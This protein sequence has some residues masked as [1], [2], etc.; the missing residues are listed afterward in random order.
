MFP[1]A[2]RVLLLTIL[3]LSTASPASYGEL[4]TS[5]GTNG[6]TRIDYTELHAIAAQP[7]GKVVVAGV[8]GNNSGGIVYRRHA[9]GD[10]DLAF[11]TNGQVTFAPS[12]VAVRIQPDGKIL[13]GLR[14][15]VFTTARLNPNGSLDPTWGTGGLAQ[16]PSDG[17][18][19]LWDVALLPDGKVLAL[20]FENVEIVPGSGTTWRRIRVQRFTADGQL[21]TSFGVAGVFSYD[22]PEN[23]SDFARN[24]VLAPNGRIYTVGVG[25]VGIRILALH[26]WGALDAS[27]GSGG[28][29]D[30]P[31]GNGNARGGALTADGTGL[32]VV[33][34][35]CGTSSCA[36][37]YL[38]ANGAIDTTFGQSGR[39][40]FGI[41]PLGSMADSVYAL[42]GGRV[43]IA[44]EAF[45]YDG[46]TS[47][48][49][50]LLDSAGNQDP[51]FNGSG[52][53]V[54]SS[55]PQGVRA[56][57]LL[58]G[59]TL[60]IAG[61]KMRTGAYFL[62]ILLVRLQGDL[63]PPETSIT[64]GPPAFTNQTT[65]QIS[66]TS[67]EPG[68]TFEC[69]LDAGAFAPC[70]SP[71]PLSGLA[72]GSHEFRVR[73]TDGTGNVDSMPAT[74]SW[75]V[76]T[77]AP[78]TVFTGGPSGT[79]ASNSATFPFWSE[80]AAAT[81][82]CSLDGAAFAPCTSPTTLSGLAQGAHV[83]EARARDAAG[84]VDPTPASATWS[85]DT[86]AP[87]TT[88]ATG[89]SGT[90]AQNSAAFT[91]TSDD[92]AAT[93][94]CS[95]DGAA[96]SACTSGASLTGL[97]EGMHMFEVR[98]VDGVGNADAT[99]AARS[100][101]VDTTNPNTTITSGPQAVTSETNATIAFTST[102]GGT[103]Q[104]ALDAAAFAPCTSP[105][106]LSSLAA[107]SHSFSVYAVDGAG[108]ADGSPA[109][110]SWFIDVTAPETTITSAPSGTVTSGSAT[111][112]FTSNDGTATF[113]C[114]LDG[115]VFAACTSPVSLSGL[116]DGAH[117]FAVRARDG[118]G[119]A[120]ASPAIA[121]WTVDATAPDTSITSAP[122][123]ASNGTS[124]S[125]S[126]AATESGSTFECKLDAGSY[127][128]C[129]S[130]RAYSGLA[131]GS[132]AFS[133]RARDAAGNQDASAAT[134]VWTIDTTA[135]NT[136]I[137]S[138]PN[139][140]NNANP[141]AFTFTSS[142]SGGTFQCSMD[143]AAFAACASGVSYSGLAKGQHTFRVRAV[144]AAGNVDASPASR[145][146]GIK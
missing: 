20:G 26:P 82:E 98:A 40:T 11:G 88:I 102:E 23:N 29:V 126:F 51:A 143:N 75:T 53:N 55:A 124:A 84:N 80:D 104:C 67:S 31:F 106:D 60:L 25:P 107:G 1:L 30:T 118:A 120:D 81:F 63:V 33:G 137:A 28:V 42:P 71:A 74:W 128:A 44:G 68:S 8:R 10:A 64:A 114:S 146:F 100:W 123:A 69:S 9:A 58:P 72:D 119:N 110:W 134:Y 3:V 27:W 145:S 141:V 105:A 83:F 4:D 50:Q 37:R 111:V 122:P 36:E 130:P 136:T 56:S 109:T 32:V 116:G 17:G 43:L 133:V 5:Y 14:G 94:Q 39:V 139:G 57:A 144:D 132:H 52:I 38:V 13:V 35:M 21:D 47:P 142:E 73:A 115:A 54:V 6:Q 16:G 121:S 138:G 113:E 96:W 48:Y 93:F 46:F 108:N 76:D 78:G 79:V 12:A 97:P 61:S 91:F 112:A 87:D 24:L 135:P 7:D 89:P 70:S 86:A 18:H 101:A 59:N 62:D 90:T 49:G 65:A 85:V 99:P 2:S 129:T 92:P 127:A 15:A 66:F 131:Q 45:D 41:A 19:E 103:F 34:G 117:A 22:R 95:L 125:F 77:A 140:G